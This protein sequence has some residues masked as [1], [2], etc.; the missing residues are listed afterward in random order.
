M[1]YSYALLLAA[2]LSSC[3][4]ATQTIELSFE[5]IMITGEGFTP[6]YGPVIWA[7]IRCPPS[8]GEDTEDTEKTE[9]QAKPTNE[10]EL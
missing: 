6:E 7:K 2:F 3:T 1:R 4:P 10:I 8:S 9:P 5:C